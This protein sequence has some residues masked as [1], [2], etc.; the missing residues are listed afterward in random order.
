M[1]MGCCTPAPENTNHKAAKKE[2][3]DPKVSSV[4]SFKKIN[5]TPSK[6]DGKN[7]LI[8]DLKEYCGQDT[9]AMVEIHRK[10]NQI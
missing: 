6:G 4:V 2:N 8:N 3:L 1:L 9:W 7:S 5:E 10:L